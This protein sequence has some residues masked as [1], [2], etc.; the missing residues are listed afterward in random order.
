MWDG[1]LRLPVDVRGVM[2][3]AWPWSAYCHARCAN[4]VQPALAA[5]SP[6][7]WIEDVAERDRSLDYEITGFG[8]P[9]GSWDAK[10]IDAI[11]P[12]ATGSR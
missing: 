12:G 4:Q 9:P 5:L 8:V 7:G 2:Q 11:K 3:P 6:H 1:S 10:V